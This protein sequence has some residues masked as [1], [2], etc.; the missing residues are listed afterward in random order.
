VQASGSLDQNQ[1]STST[2]VQDQQQ[3]ASTSS[4]PNVQTSASNQVQI[5]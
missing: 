5:L 3:V 2:Q 1:A 4:Q